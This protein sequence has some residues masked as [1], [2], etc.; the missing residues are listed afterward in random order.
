MPTSQPNN[1]LEQLLAEIRAD[2]D[3]K[4]SITRFGEL[5]RIA[6]PPAREVSMLDGIVG[7]ACREFLLRTKAEIP[8]ATC[9]FCQRRQAEVFWL[10]RGPLVTICDLCITVAQQAL[11]EARLRKKPRWYQAIHRL[12]TRHDKRFTVSQGKQT[13]A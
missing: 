1:S 6:N 2:G 5:L 7:N 11:A 12:F 3:S 9:D 10:V 13:A 8:E 4:K